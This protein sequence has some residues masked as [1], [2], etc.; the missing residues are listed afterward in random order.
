MGYTSDVAYVI[1]FKDVEERDA[2]VTLMQAK[3]D[4]YTNQ[5]LEE[6]E[7]RYSKDPI[8]TFECT[9]TKWYENYPDVKA[10]HKLMHDAE[11]LYEAEYRFVRVGEDV[12]DVEI[13][14]C[15]HD[16]ELWQY[17]EPVRQISTDFPPVDVDVKTEFPQPETATN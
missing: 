14:E 16:Y 1:K 3:N 13:D 5:A 17:V 4:Q 10:H 15:G 8:I 2:F 6:V 7:Y 12:D 11:E 9:Y